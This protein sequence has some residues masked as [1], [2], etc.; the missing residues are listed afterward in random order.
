MQA[1]SIVRIKNNIRQVLSHYGYDARTIEDLSALIGTEHK[2]YA[3]SRD[4]KRKFV[5]LDLT[6]EIPVKCCFLIR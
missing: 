5:S 4:G 3:V 6:V 2:V 1:G